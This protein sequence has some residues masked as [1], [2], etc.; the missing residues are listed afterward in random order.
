MTVRA[1]ISKEQENK[2]SERKNGN[3]T[4]MFTLVICKAPCVELVFAS[5]V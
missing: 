4:S 3:L 2:A 5:T 1:L